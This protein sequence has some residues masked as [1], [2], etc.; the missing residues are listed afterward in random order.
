MNGY[1]RHCLSRNELFKSLRAKNSGGFFRTGAR[2]HAS[3]EEC[4]QALI[5]LIEYLD[6]NLSTLF[7]NLREDV[8]QL[9]FSHL[10]KDILSIIESIL[11]PPLSDTPSNMT[12]LDEYELNM[13]F[14]CLEVC[15]LGASWWLTKG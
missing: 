14:G 13:T 10:W 1:I 15:F 5:P 4:D 12:P 8:A 7:T 9:V 11:V 2:E 3:R 6:L